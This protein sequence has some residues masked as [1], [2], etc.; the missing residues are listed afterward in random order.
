V[1][2]Q[3]VEYTILAR[4]TAYTDL[5]VKEATKTGCTYIILTEV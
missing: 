1:E 2:E 5:S 4:V 3:K